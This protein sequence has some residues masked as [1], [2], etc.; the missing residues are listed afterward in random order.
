MPDELFRAT[1]S[2]N[3]APNSDIVVHTPHFYPHIGADHKVTKPLMC[4]HTVVYDF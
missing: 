3:S 1:H 4:K 2:H